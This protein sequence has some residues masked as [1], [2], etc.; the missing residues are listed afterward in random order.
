MNCRQKRLIDRHDLVCENLFLYERS[1]WMCVGFAS[2]GWNR[3]KFR[4][5]RRKNCQGFGRRQRSVEADFC[6]NVSKIG[7]MDVYILG[8]LRYC[9]LAVNKLDSFCFESSCGFW[10]YFFIVKSER[11]TRARHGVCPR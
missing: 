5:L 1:D 6:V 7:T 2:N 4:S 3:T 9:L 11:S 8:Y 10:I